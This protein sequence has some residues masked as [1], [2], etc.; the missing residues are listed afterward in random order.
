LSPDLVA[1]SQFDAA[2]PL[3]FGQNRFGQIV[4][5]N[6]WSIKSYRPYEQIGCEMRAREELDCSPIWQPT[7]SE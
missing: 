3:R 4:H 2:K 7:S 1:I 6:V 5:S